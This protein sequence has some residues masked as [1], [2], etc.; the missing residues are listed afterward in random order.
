[1]LLDTRDRRLLLLHPR[2]S[3]PV[4]VARARPP[5]L[6][7]VRLQA[8]ADAFQHRQLRRHKR[9][10]IGCGH[11]GVEKG[12][13]VRGRDVECWAEGAGLLLEDIDGFGGG[14]GASISRGLERSFAFRDEGREG[15]GSAVAVED[16]LVADHDHLDVLPVSTAGP[17]GDFI[18]LSFC[19][20]N[21]GVGDEYAEDEFEAVGGGC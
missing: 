15:A 11:I 3:R 19:F 10:G 14:D 17:G 16:S 1:M 13:D 21:A 8:R 2:T 18:D 9:P 6:K 7:I 20:G 12:M 4:R 5:G